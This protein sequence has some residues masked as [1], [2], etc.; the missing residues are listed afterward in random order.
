MSEAS[1]S[2]QRNFIARE[3]A[4]RLVLSN[5]LLK[6][7]EIPALRAGNHIFHNLAP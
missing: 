7:G 1:A 2:S 3:N 6:R 5:E 4:Y